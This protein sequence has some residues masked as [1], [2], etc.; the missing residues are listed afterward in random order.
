MK[1]IIEKTRAKDRE[2]AEKRSQ[3]ERIIQWFVSRENQ[4]ALLRNMRKIRELD[5]APASGKGRE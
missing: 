3:K 2:E 4:I 5:Y 1:F